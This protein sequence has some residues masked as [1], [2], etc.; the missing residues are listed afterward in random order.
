MS[1]NNQ[2]INYG[3]ASPFLV[4]SLP[5]PRRC[6]AGGLSYESNRSPVVERNN[7]HTVPAG[8]LTQIQIIIESLR[9]RGPRAATSPTAVHCV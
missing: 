3:M 9:L 5:E 4:L 2:L 8:R 7:G 6:N 1:L